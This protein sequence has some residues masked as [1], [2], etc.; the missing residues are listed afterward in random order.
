MTLSIYKIV[1]YDDDSIS[2]LKSDIKFVRVSEFQSFRVSEFQSFRVSESF[3]EFQSFRVSEFQ[4]LLTVKQ[5]ITGYSQYYLGTYDDNLINLK[6]IPDRI[7]IMSNYH[8]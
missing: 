8:V 3:R 1:F 5:L 2:G 6:K 4:S 7:T